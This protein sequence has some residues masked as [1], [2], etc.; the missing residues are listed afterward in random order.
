[1]GK[2]MQE[3]G[4][5]M[6]IEKYRDNSRL[7]RSVWWDK[8]VNSERGTVHLREL[9]GEKVFAFPK[10][11][12]LISRIIEISTLENDIILDY[13]LG[14]GTTATTAHKMGRRYIGI[15]QMNYIEDISVERLKKV[16]GTIGKKEN[17]LFD[18]EIIIDFDEAGISKEVN[19]Q[20][21]G[22]FVYCELM[23]WNE[24]FIAKINNAENTDDL[25]KIYTRIKEKAF[26]NYKFDIEK[27][28]DENMK[29]FKE[30]KL[31]EQK[32]IIK[33]SLDLN[34]LYI[35]LSEIE[36]ETYNISDENKKLN[37]IFY[38]K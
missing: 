32:E 1:M 25:I 5:Y 8:G 15:E 6:I 33:K 35:N 16:I 23:K 30:L 13:H 19:W 10:P 9:F 29:D 28:E 26:L 3:D 24:L 21:G 2:K 37:K 36:D 27:F 34:S 22:S 18:S 17:A 38:K 31:E 20:G 4:R 12:T 11:E 7:A 14:S